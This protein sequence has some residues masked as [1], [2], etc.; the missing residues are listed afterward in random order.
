MSVAPPTTTQSAPP[1]SGA[2]TTVVVSVSAS[3]VS[4]CSPV[5]TPPAP[6][7]S[8][9]STIEFSPELPLLTQRPS[10]WP[11]PV[12]SGALLLSVPPR[13]GSTTPVAA[14]AAVGTAKVPLPLPGTTIWQVLYGPTLQSVPATRSDGLLPSKSPTHSPSALD[15]PSFTCAGDPLKV[16]DPLLSQT[17]TPSDS[18]RKS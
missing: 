10:G 5:V 16:F 2:A 18:D 15:M 13:V 1:V 12:R 3:P 6:L 14:S 11:S 7:P 4:T 8:P 17:S 9:T